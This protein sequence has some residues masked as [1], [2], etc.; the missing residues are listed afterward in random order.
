MLAAA[1][2]NTDLGAGRDYGNLDSVSVFAVSKAVLRVP[3]LGA[4]IRTSL[5][6]GK[7]MEVVHF[8][9]A[10]LVLKATRCFVER[11]KKK[12]NKRGKKWSLRTLTFRLLPLFVG[13]CRNNCYLSDNKF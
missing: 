6:P 12:K 4:A 2:L 5:A 10:G 1:R 8:R 11:H 9:W 3:A 13:L 7:W